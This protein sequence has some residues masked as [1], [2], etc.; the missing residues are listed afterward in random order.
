MMKAGPSDAYAPVRRAFEGRIV[1]LAEVISVEGTDIN[2]RLH[3]DND[4]IVRIPV[5]AFTWE[6]H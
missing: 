6:Y 3:L 5:S 1:V 2:V 4:T